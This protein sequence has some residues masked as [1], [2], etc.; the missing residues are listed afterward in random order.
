TTPTDAPT[1]SSPP[2][3]QPPSPFFKKPPG[4]PS[5]AV[6]PVWS[7][8]LWPRQPHASAAPREQRPPSARPSTTN[9]NGLAPTTSE[10]IGRPNRAERHRRP[11]D[12]RAEPHPP[13]PAKRQ[14]RKSRTRPTD[15]RHQLP[16]SPAHPPA[17]SAAHAF[18]RTCDRSTQRR[19]QHRAAGVPTRRSITRH[20]PGPR[21]A[22]VRN[23]S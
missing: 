2:P 10:W 6:A 5:P 12:W 19:E 15:P 17:D 7:A 8:P 23:R 18:A 11:P 16:R 3:D 14:R 20:P 21:G 22:P 4:G 1:P 9:S 13:T